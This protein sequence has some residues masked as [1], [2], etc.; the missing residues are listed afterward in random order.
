M[1]GVTISNAART[2]RVT[3]KPMHSASI[4]QKPFI[5]QP[6]LLAPV[7]PGETMKSFLLQSR[8][9]TAPIANPLVGWWLEYYIFYVKHRDLD[10]RDDFSE[11]MLD[12]D[13]DMSS[14]NESASAVYYH[15]AGQINWSKLCLKRV[16]E[17]YFRKPDEA[18]TDFNVDSM[19]LS[20]INQDGIFNSLVLD[21]DFVQP[22]DEAITVGVDDQI[23]A[24]EIDAT[25]RTWQF[26]RANGLTPMDYED[27]LATYGITP[28]AEEHHRPELLR[29]VREWQYPSNTVDPTTGVPSSAV[30]WAISE[31]ADKDRFF[32]EPGFVFGVTV[33][34]PKVYLRNQDGSVSD[35]L[36]DAM[37]WLPAIMRDDPWSSVRKR[38]DTQMPYSVVTDANGYW[39]DIKDL[40]LYGDQFVNYAVSGVTNA[41][42]VDLPTATL[43]AEY[44]DTDDIDGF[45]AGTSKLIS[46]DIA[47]Q[48]T[49]LGALRDTTPN[50]RGM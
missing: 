29:Y 39:L 7:L 43:N 19:P 9:V 31:R 25:L 45:F 10:G 24:S 36:Q 42:L 18:F 32:R 5:I 28:K 33:A 40:F 3:R 17:E 23:T 8:A 38:T 12:M 4:R 20:R 50:M 44:P 13:K 1:A 15:A 6:F 47:V 16:V 41:N 35:M 30:S 27:W 49:I 37:G 11:M 34:R 2:G 26:Q 14:Y 22:A 46:Q 21:D 48:M